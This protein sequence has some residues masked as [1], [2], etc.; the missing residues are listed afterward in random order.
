MLL[1]QVWGSVGGVE[2]HYLHV[3]VPA[4]EEAGTRPTGAAVHQ[5]RAGDWL[6]AVDRLDA[7]QG[8]PGSRNRTQSSAALCLRGGPPPHAVQ[9][10]RRSRA[11]R[12]LLPPAA[13]QVRAREHQTHARQWRRSPATPTRRAHFLRQQA[14]EP[15]DHL[16]RWYGT[17]ATTT[18]GWN[19][20]AAFSR[21]AVWLCSRCSHQCE[22]TSSG[23]TT[24]TVS[25]GWLSWRA[26]I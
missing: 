24:T 25:S 16:A 23:T 11:P 13:A 20:R 12:S 26:S 2:A 21:K 5:E 1:Q 4:A 15:R 14:L 7:P 22:G 6:P 17:F 9:L 18:P 10:L 3:Y 8:R 19:S